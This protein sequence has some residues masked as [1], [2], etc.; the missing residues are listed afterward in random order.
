MYCDNNQ[1]PTLLFCASHPN[2][3]GA[4][5]LGKH[6]HLRFDPSLGH[7]ICAICRIIF[8]C[9][10][11]TSMIDKPW[12]SGI[13]SIKLVHYQPIINFNYWQ[14][15]APYNDWDTIHLSVMYGAINIDDKTSN[16]LYIIQFHSEAY[17]LKNNTT[18]DG[19]VIS[20]GKLVFRSQYICSMQ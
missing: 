18:I 16:G 14:V 2:P 8:A 12:I 6:Y 15:L 9:V 7:G 19:Q 10:A 3:N 13:Q 11:C 1:L 5:G 17:T 4:R 20:T